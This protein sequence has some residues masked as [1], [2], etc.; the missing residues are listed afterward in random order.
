MER[1]FNNKL[2]IYYWA[3]DERK[4]SG[5][6]ILANLFISDIK[7]YYTKYTL[8]NTN[9]KK[10][11]YKKF[12]NKY[13]LNILGALKLWIYFFQGYKILYVN[14]LPI[15]NFLIFFILPPK[16][17]MGPITG[18]S[19]HNGNSLLNVF[20]RKYL[21][22]LFEKIS[23]LIVFYRQKKVLFSTE[24]LKFNLKKSYRMRAYFNYALSSFEGF[25]KQRVKKIDFLIYHRIHDNKNNSLIKYFLENSMHKKLK[26][27]VFGDRINSNNV[28]NMG[29]IS[30]DKVK[31]LLT[32][33]KFTFGSSE[34]FYTFYVQDA[35]S[36][37]VVIFYDRNLKIF[38][39][40][41]NYNKIIPLNFNNNEESLKIIFKNIK[42]KF[43]V[44]K[45]NYSIK[46][47]YNEYFNQF[48]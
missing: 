17:I 27:I 15:W 26:I 32:N 11:N 18:S 30:R 40:K 34:N 5:E 33:A 47:N 45:K 23:L 35:I 46:K 22:N 41:I 37:N 16:T 1:I 28:H 9:N 44:T 36:R 24:L 13:I 19:I 8:I 48:S 6:G 25:L 4:N 21:F 29:Y 38:S 20:F 2:K 14:Y 3:S 42:K 31:K 43:A 7:K 10:K 12:Y 39:N